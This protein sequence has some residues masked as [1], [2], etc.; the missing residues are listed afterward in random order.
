MA[1]IGSL[2]SERNPKALWKA[3]QELVEE[4]HDL[5]AVFQ[6]NLIGLVSDEVLQSIYEHHLKDF[7][8]VIGYV[9]HSEAIKAQMQSR[10]LL[11]IEIDSEDTRAIIPGK[12]FEYMASETPII[13]I[14]P[15]DS[16]VEQII[17][18]TNTGYYFCYD[19][20]NGIKS[21]ILF[22][23]DAYKNNALATFPIGLKQF[24]RKELTSKLAH[25]IFKNTE[26]DA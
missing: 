4:H 9:S 7:V 6:L 22:Y 16:A 8:N 13:A 11:L 26:A 14:G 23:F 12:L 15:K 19:E 3:L 2:L 5:K 18:T 17:K 1:H 20:K 24:S 25:L 21:Q 10:V